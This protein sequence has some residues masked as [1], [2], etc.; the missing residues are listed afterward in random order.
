MSTI[1]DRREMHYFDLRIF[2]RS[3][4]LPGN[5]MWERLRL[6]AMKTEQE[7]D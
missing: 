7:Q 4:A 1:D 6:E 3:Q 2:P 5:A